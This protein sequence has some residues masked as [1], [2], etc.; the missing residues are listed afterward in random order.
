MENENNVNNMIYLGGIRKY[1][2]QIISLHRKDQE[3]PRTERT[4]GSRG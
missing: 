4:L 1:L 2:K 3:L